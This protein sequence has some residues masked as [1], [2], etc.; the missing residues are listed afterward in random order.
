MSWHVTFAS[1]TPDE[2]LPGSTTFRV[3]GIS[4]ERR[5]GYVLLVDAATLALGH[6]IYADTL[7][8]I[9]HRVDAACGEGVRH[10]PG[11][12]VS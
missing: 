4:G 5:V 1:V 9:L 7:A 11:E 3:E 8:R 10:T 6:Y 12:W 2:H